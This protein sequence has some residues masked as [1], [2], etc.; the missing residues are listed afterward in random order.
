MAR[1][2]VVVDANIWVSYLF[3][4]KSIIAEVGDFLVSGDCTV[5]AS[6]NSLK[7]LLDVLK[8]AEWDRYLSLET[9]LTFYQCVHEISEI[10]AIT[11]TITASRDPKDD[12]LLNAAHDGQA[13]YLVTGDNDL[14]TLAS[15]PAPD[16]GFH[17][18]TPANFL[19]SLRKP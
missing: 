8:R 4:A 2:R 5:I 10:T 3:F 15:A 18:V 11:G 9:R 19:D 7:E 13:D 14:L 6:G 17:I 1:P 12:E 16:W